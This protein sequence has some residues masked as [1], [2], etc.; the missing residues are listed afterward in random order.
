MCLLFAFQVDL[1]SFPCAWQWKKATVVSSRP[2]GAAIGVCATRADS[3]TPHIYGQAGRHLFS[4]HRLPRHPSAID[5]QGLAGD[6]PA[7]AIA[8]EEHG[9]AGEVFGAAPARGGDALEDLHVTDGVG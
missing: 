1:V 6:V 3:R 2:V 9:R 4:L 7:R 8:G 5:H